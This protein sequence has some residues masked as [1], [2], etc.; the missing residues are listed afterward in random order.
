[1]NTIKIKTDCVLCVCVRYE[2]GPK[3]QLTIWT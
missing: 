2:L 3:K 1:M